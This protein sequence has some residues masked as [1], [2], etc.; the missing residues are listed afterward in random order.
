MKKRILLITFLLAFCLTGCGGTG[1]KLTQEDVVGHGAEDYLGSYTENTYKNERYSIHFTSPSR[2][3]EFAILDE[4]L[5]ANDISD[6]GYTNKNVAS[7]L[8]SGK[9]FMTM[10]GG[11]GELHTSTSVVLSPLPKGT[12][13]EQF[14]N[15]SEQ[16]IKESLEK[17]TSIKIKECELKSGSPIGNDKYLSYIIEANNQSFYTVQFYAFT[18]TD[19]AGITISAGSKKEIDKL[20]KSWKKLDES[21]SEGKSESKSESNKESAKGDQ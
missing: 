9:D 1:S 10:Y 18:D 4:I 3:F 5:T 6:E 20:F 7:V 15:T 8:A 11:D 2:D 21:S 14:M 16:K 17:D 19:V 12:T 13:Q